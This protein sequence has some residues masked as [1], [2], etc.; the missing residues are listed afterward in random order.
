MIQKTIL[1][2]DDEKDILELVKRYLLQEG[3]DVVVAETGE[4]ALEIAHSRLP[5]LI[6]LDLM[7]PGIDGLD[8]CKMLKKNPKT[9]N[10]PVIILSGKS[11]DSDIVTSFEVGAD[12]YIT[13]PF[14]P[15]VL[16]ARIR[17]VLRRKIEQSSDER[18][19]NIHDLRMDPDRFKAF[20]GDKQLD[21][22]YSEFNI[23]Y[24]LAKHPGVVFSRH[25]INEVINKGT[26][27]V[28]DRAVDVQ[29]TY[30]RKKLGNYRKYI[31]TVRG[32]GYRFKG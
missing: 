28:T 25:Q 31:E 21:L 11:E 3:Y 17:R 9:R 30:L 27:M 26:Y 10:I 24:V 8:L 18:T 23:L 12:D 1:I 2:I 29:I 32:V 19:I 15:K 13:K 7:L 6:V 5:T 20:L 4:Q 16:V 22:T 14:S